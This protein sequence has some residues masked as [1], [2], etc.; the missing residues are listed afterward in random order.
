MGLISNLV[1]PVVGAGM[2]LLLEGHEDDRQQ[3]QQQALTDIQSKANK[4]QMDYGMGLQ[5]D[6]WNYTN[7]EN[8]MKHIEDA[9]L[10]PGLLY[11]MKGGGGVTTGSPGTGGASGGTAAPN[12]GGIGMGMQLAQ[13]ALLDAQKKNIDADTENKKAESSY[14]TGAK[15]ANTNEDTSL[16]GQQNAKTAAEAGTAQTQ[17]E[18]AEATKYDQET[19]IKAKALA[20]AESLDQLYRA[21]HMQEDTYQD[22]VKNIAATAAGQVLKNKMTEEQINQIKQGIKMGWNDL[23]IKQQLATGQLQNKDQDQ[24]IEVIRTVLQT[25][26]RGVIGG[27]K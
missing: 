9:G 6:M 4:E 24:V 18:V 10:N 25:L 21:G 12:N 19:S 15:T 27:H 5:K 23:Q 1:G 8:Q 20:D 2:G 17:Q 22:G 16:K 14:T 13:L 3:K 7:Y 26:T 11:G